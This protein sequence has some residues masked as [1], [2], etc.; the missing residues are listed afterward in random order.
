MLVSG[1]D[2]LPLTRVA[3]VELPEGHP[4]RDTFDSDL[5]SMRATV[6]EIW[7][8]TDVHGARPEDE[9]EELFDEADC[10]LILLN[11]A[12]GAVNFEGIGD[13]IEDWK[14]AS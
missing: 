9:V 6:D 14:A 7:W 4:D 13:E 8:R 3:P 2:A 11:I 1:L 12:I 10:G 5:S